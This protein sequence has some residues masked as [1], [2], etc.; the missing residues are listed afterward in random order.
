MPPSGSEF[1]GVPLPE[2]G[3]K[4]LF[5][6]NLA[7]RLVLALADL[8]PNSAHVGNV[9]LEGSPMPLFGRMPPQR[10]SFSSRRT[11]ISTD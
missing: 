4:L 8:Y 5:D 10:A 1:S 7:P 6:E 2:P 9:G 3:P 11:R